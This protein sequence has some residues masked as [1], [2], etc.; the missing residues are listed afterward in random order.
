MNEWVWRIGG[1]ILQGVNERT[2]REVW[3]NATVHQKPDI[4]LSGIE[5]KFSQWEVLDK[6]LESRHDVVN[7]PVRNWAPFNTSVL[8]SV[9]EM[10]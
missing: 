9:V 1:I 5:P 6:Q 2:L 3:A 4:E 7:F 10:M 8:N